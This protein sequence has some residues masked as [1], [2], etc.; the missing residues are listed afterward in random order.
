MFTVKYINTPET[1]RL[2]T[3][4]RI[5]VGLKKCVTIT[6]GFIVPCGK[7]EVGGCWEN[8][9]REVRE[10]LPAAMLTGSPPRKV[11]IDPATDVALVQKVVRFK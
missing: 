7:V 8:G 10:A 4:E 11:V 6:V 2:S 5:Q 9:A 3:A 1:S